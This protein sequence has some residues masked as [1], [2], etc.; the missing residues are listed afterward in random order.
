M[1]FQP[2][3]LSSLLLIVSTI[4]STYAD[5]TAAPPSSTDPIPIFSIIP[6]ASTPAPLPASSAFYLIVADTGTPFDGDY[7]YVGEAF[8]GDGLFLLLFGK[9]PALGG[10]SVFHLSNGSYG[11]L[12]FDPSGYVA[13]YYDLYGGLLFQDPDPALLEAYGET[14]ATC[15]LGDVILC[16]NT[17]YAVF[18]TFPSTVV[19]GGSTV[20]YMELGPVP[21]PTGAIPIR[22]LPVPIE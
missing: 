3:W 17:E 18:Y 7:L 4:T 9:G 5:T 13:T 19:D 16:Q 20:P 1:L 2:C 8:G 11:S 12:T 15:E 14:P 21:I 10:G 6:A 22:V